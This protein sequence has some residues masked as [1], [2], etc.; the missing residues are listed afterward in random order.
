MPL[1]YNM[2]EFRGDPVRNLFFMIN[3]VYYSECNYQ[4]KLSGL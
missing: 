2:E 3:E 1:G 4:L